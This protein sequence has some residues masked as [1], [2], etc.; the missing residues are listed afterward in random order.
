MPFA[1]LIGTM[2]AT[3]DPSSFPIRWRRG[4]DY[5]IVASSRP[6]TTLLERS[7]L[8]YWRQLVV[9]YIPLTRVAWFVVPALFGYPGQSI[10]FG[11]VRRQYR[12]RYHQCTTVLGNVLFDHAYK[13]NTMA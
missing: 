3:V 12:R 2:R 6:R 7:Q 11:P 13:R 5:G 8:A 4:R 9:P 10:P 1:V